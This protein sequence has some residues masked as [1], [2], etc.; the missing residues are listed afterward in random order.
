MR[1]SHNLNTPERTHL[2]PDALEVRSRGSLR[3]RLSRN[4]A[5][6]EADKVDLGVRDREGG[7]FRREMYDLEEVRGK[8]SA[9]PCQR[10][11]LRCER[12]LRG[13]LEDHGVAGD[14]SGEDRVDRGEVGVAV[15]SA[16]GEWAG[17]DTGEIQIHTSMAQ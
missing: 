2:K 14:K 3:D 9:C 13:G 5:P 17:E 6:S 16:S 8:P 10:E 12:G 1:S 11:T 4:Y 7:E 15:S